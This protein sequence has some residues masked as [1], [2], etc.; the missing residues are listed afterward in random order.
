MKTRINLYRD[1][2]KPRFV[3]ISANN[4]FL[5]GIVALI[6]MATMYF[7]VWQDLQT[8]QQEL[9]EIQKS[10]ESKQ[11]ELD[12]L[13][14]QFTARAKDPKL[15]AKLANQ[16]VKLATAK[17]LAA[18]LNTLSKLQERPFSSALNSFAEA[19]NASVWLTSFKLNDKHILINGNISEPS[20]LPIWL[21]SIGKTDFFNNR[22][23]GAAA[24][25]RTNEKL[26]FSIE[27]HSQIT[28]N[29]MEASNE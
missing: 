9:T 20:A 5:F 22:D 7:G 29:S 13:T 8:Q 2:F 16:Q 28:P 10:I 1:E 3:W 17:H 15:L 19:N 18:K 11:Q 6:L 12:Q 4:T 14:N 26:S 21:K 27:S 24:L 23:F 25:L